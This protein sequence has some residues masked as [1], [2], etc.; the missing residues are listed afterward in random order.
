MQFQSRNTNVQFKRENSLMQ[1]RLSNI[2]GVL[3]YAPLRHVALSTTLRFVQDDT[4][5]RLFFRRCSGACNRM[6]HALFLTKK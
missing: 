5:I 3:H 2:I 1:N 4:S 6:S